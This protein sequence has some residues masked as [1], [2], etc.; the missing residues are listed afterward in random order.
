MIS[1]LIV[2]VVIMISLFAVK[3]S[4]LPPQIP[5]FYTRPWGEEQLADIWMIFMLPFLMTI[6]FLFNNY[7]SNRFFKDNEL[8]KKIFSIVNIFIII[9]FTLIFT[10]IIFLIS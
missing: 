8:I 7:V 2:A 1:L 3:Y 4:M 6:F 10:K 5:L 9:T